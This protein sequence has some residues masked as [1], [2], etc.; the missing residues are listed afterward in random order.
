MNKKFTALVVVGATLAALPA[1]A[2]TA[3][4][5]APAASALRHGTAIPGLCV[6]SGEVAVSNSQVGKFVGERLR[7]LEAPI[8]ADL[9]TQIQ[10][11]EQ[12]VQTFN[13]QRAS[14]TPEAAEQQATGLAQRR[15]Q[16]QQLA[17][18]RAR[19]GQLTQQKAIERI[20]SEMTPLVTQAYNTRNCAVLLD[21]NVIMAVNPASDLTPDVVRLLDAKITQFTFDRERIDAAAA[22][23]GAAAP[24]AAPAAPAAPAARR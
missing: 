20:N 22:G 24:A 9:N 21:G 10:Q 14:L 23:A 2:Q 11:F 18:V 16:L 7:Q 19:E 12:S 15:A 1:F 5:A 13:T 17:Q 6:F 8:E 3:A 4:P